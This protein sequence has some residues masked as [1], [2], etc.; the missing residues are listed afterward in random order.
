MFISINSLINSCKGG[1]MRKNKSGFTLVEILIA[2]AIVGVVAALTIPA[3]I[4]RINNKVKNTRITTIETKLK[5]STDKLMI[6]DNINGYKTTEN[7]VEALSKHMKIATFCSADKISECFPYN[8]INVDGEEEGVFV[9]DLKT[10]EAFGLSSDDYSNPVSFITGDGVPY[11]IMYKKECSIDDGDTTANSKAC[12]AGI[13]DWN[14][15]RTPNR[16]IANIY[17]DSNYDNIDIQF[18]GNIKQ[19]GNHRIAQIDGPF[20]KLRRLNI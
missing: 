7:F 2:L 5:Q 3:L 8:K 16:F 1:I 13:Y 19:I 9:T 14:G 12:I 4:T 11:I 18:L 15:T 20:Y 17:P 10:P 6:M